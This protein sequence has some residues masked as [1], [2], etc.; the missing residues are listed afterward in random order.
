ME[1]QTP[2]YSLKNIPVPPRHIYEKQLVEKSESLLRRM[3]WKLFAHRNPDLFTHDYKNF[4]FN[5]LNKPP[6]DKD[7]ENFENDFLDLVSPINIVY[8]KVE[9]DFQKELKTE[10][11]N[12]NNSDKVMVFA[13]KT[14]N[15]YHVPVDTYQKQVTDS[16]TSDYRKCDP[17]K[18]DAVNS[19]ACDITEEFPVSAIENLSERV[20]CLNKN[21]AF[22]T[23]KD[24]KE[25]F[26]GKIETR[27][28]NP[29][30]TNVG[31]ISKAILDRI[32]RKLREKTGLNQF[33]SSKQVAQWFDNIGNKSEYSFL[34]LDICRFYPSISEKLLD[35]AIKWAKG[36]TPITKQ[37]I[38]IIKHCRKT[39]LFFKGES[40]IKLK[41][42]EHDNPMG[43]LDGAEIAELI[44]L[45]LLFGLKKI[46]KKED[47][48]LFRDDLI[49]V[50]KLSGP[51]A[52]RLRKKLFDFFKSHGLSIEVQCNI[53]QT[54]YLDLFMDLESGTRAPYRKEDTAPTYINVSSNHPKHIIDNLPTMISQ[55]ISML[56]SNEE[57]FKQVAPIYN[58]GLRQAGYLEEIKYIPPQ[59]SQNNKTR[60]RRRNVIWFCPPHNKAVVTNIG[61]R[62]L[63]LIDKHFPRGSE[64]G[65]LFNRNN[66]KISY[67][68]T[69]SI[70]AIITSHNQ[71]LLNPMTNLN[72]RLCSC[73]RTRAHN[74]PL[75]GKCL[76][77]NIIYSSKVVTAN[78]SREY[79]GSTSTDFKTRLGNHRS[80]LTAPSRLEKGT[81][82]STYIKSLNES[83]TPYNQSWNIEARAQ[84][85][86]PE[87]GYCNLCLVEKYFI[88]KFFKER[89]LVNKRTEL[90]G[91]C[92]HKTPF[93]L[94]NF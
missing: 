71:K 67:S 15:I 52:E 13:D 48:A 25:G 42:E 92:R 39:F 31:K 44:G 12:I 37:E 43:C 7:L 29:S 18:V 79:I 78:E 41:N 40:W 49:A 85:Y 34:K 54:D 63:G 32:N 46:I 10:V 58:E 89:K 35:A 61:R 88:L 62:F 33:Q 84:P 20:D 83:N 77:S 80:D 26:P 3:R 47:T 28:I 82:L 66:V 50:V 69:K 59:D 27:L 68:C 24:T 16:I 2:T 38:K 19:E 6:P 14:K 23:I 8:R 93:L 72:Q 22:I 17:A 60:R 87:I 4:G 90:L 91:R 56:S 65:K 55:R 75:G 73:P 53:K 86:K 5:S 74:C 9:D 76:N 21:E 57:I 81:T 64:L 51:Q 70:K 30:K 11:R 94:K 45:F 1:K 36:L